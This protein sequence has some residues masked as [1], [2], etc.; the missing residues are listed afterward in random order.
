MKLNEIDTT[1]AIEWV[2]EFGERAV[3]HKELCTHG[4]HAKF[5]FHR[6]IWLV[7][8]TPHCWQIRPEALIYLQQHN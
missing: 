3:P 6:A 7:N 4:W 5:I 8:D 1:W 2:L